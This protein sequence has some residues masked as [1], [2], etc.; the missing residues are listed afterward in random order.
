MEEQIEKYS[1]FKTL[2]KYIYSNL[3]YFIIN[4]VLTFL[5]TIIG[6]SIA[7][8]FRTLPLYIN[9]IACIIEAILIVL[10]IYISFK[11]NKNVSQIDK[12]YL[13]SFTVFFIYLFVDA[14]ILSAILFIWFKLQPGF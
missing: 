2:G 7:P 1:Y 3:F 13:S 8:F 10:S 4:F 6:Y 12:K 5:I 9:I 11:M 14:F